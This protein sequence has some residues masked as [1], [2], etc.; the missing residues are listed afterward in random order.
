[1]K[2]AIISAALATLLLGGVASAQPAN[3]GRTLTRA[4]TAARAD[5]Q[6]TRLDANRDG[7][8]T[9][10]ELSVRKQARRAAQGNGDRVARR[11]ARLDADGNGAVTLA[12]MRTAQ[13]NRG[14]RAGRR[15]NRGMARGLGRMDANGDGTIT[16][17]EFQANALTRFARL[18][19]N[20]DGTVTP[21][22]RQNRRAR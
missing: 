13:A 3:G 15:G 11:F 6:F 17:A 10:A 22:E 14:E 9:A 18:D 19:A 20:N 7:T 1:M 2:T 8:V 5:R 12:E 21:V 4:D 16:R